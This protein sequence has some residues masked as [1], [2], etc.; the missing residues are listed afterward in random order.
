MSTLG[1]YS[2]VLGATF[3]AAAAIAHLACIALGPPAYRFM[4]AG[5]KMARAVEAGSLR[6]T[7][8]TLALSAVLG[9]WAVYAF[10]GAGLLAPLPL[11]KPALVAITAVY[12]VRAFAFPL[13]RPAFPENSNA[14][15]V[16]S[17]GICLIIGLLHAYGLSSRW[18]A[19]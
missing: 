1:T 3:S 17:S 14:F 13:L 12:L 18:A 5:E 16:I 8:L 6:P 9:V 2:L 10:S 4:G 7:V 11:A 15:W 19:L